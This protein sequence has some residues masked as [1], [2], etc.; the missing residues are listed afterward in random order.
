MIL[1]V[2]GSAAIA[3]ASADG[4]SGGLPLPRF[5]SLR[6]DEVNLR[7]GPGTQYPVEWVYRRRMLPV[8]I[9][10]EHHNWRRIRDW[11]GDEGWV[12]RSLLVGRRSILV[13]GGV[14]EVRATTDPGSRR[15][16]R[17]EP[18]VSGLLIACPDPGP[19]C[20]VRFGRTEGWLARSEFWGAYP[21]E[22]V[23]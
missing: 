18:G 8:E 9:V 17:V 7:A 22:V 4:G 14:A 11:Q 3:T 16:A 21:G 15:I 10:A 1:V 5:V 13:T 19:F 20:R 2:A 12:H 23:R 6:A